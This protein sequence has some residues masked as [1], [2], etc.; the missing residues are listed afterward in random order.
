MPSN[1]VINKTAVR[2]KF[3]SVEIA[4]INDDGILHE[5]AQR[6]QIERT[7]LLPISKDEQRVRVSGGLDRIGHKTDATARQELA[8]AIGGGGI[9]CHHFRAFFEQS[10]ND[11]DGGRLANIVGATFE[12]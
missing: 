5:R 3:R 1:A 4:A 6:N 9:I 7:K 11:G 8:S 12:G 10:L 2:H